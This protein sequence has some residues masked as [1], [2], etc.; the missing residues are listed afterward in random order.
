MTWAQWSGFQSH[1]D[2][3]NSV[4]GEV[5]D[6]VTAWGSREQSVGCHMLVN[7]TENCI[8][9]FNEADFSS[10]MTSLHGTSMQTDPPTYECIWG[11]RCVTSVC[12]QSPQLCLA[13][14]AN[15]YLSERWGNTSK[16]Y[17][18]LIWDYNCFTPSSHQRGVFGSAASSKASEKG[19]M[20]PVC[21]VEARAT[22]REKGHQLNS[23]LW[24]TYC[25]LP[26]IPA[27]FSLSFMHQYAQLGLWLSQNSRGIY[28]WCLHCMITLH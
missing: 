14:T 10:A 15:H 3:L 8:I 9:T 13:G 25:F 17:G 2:W 22:Q 6:D 21:Y 7:T 20:D 24:H 1:S 26:L 18:Y 5:S 28:R 27:Q 23:H 4:A 19:C 11:R 16:D 12:G